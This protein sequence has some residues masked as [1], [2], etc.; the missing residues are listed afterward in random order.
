MKKT[1]GIS[2]IFILLFCGV[3]YSWAMTQE[4]RNEISQK[5]NAVS[6]SPND[7]DAHFDLA[8]TYAY[9]NKVEAGLNE[10]KKTSTLVKD[11]KAYAKELI[12]RYFDLVKKNPED[13]KL[14]FRLGFAYYF[15]DYKKYAMDELQNV[16]NVNPG[17]PWPY[18][19]MAIIAAEDNKWN[20]GILYMKKA[21]AIDSNV[22][23]FHLGLGQGYYKTG[24]SVKGFFE[25]AEA[26]RLRAIG[27]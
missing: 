22:A 24:N 11:Q 26:L 20:D 15:G 9:T 27:Y 5:E 2:I 1:A 4:Y 6:R 14:R 23:A 13:W 7:P 18:G 3:A 10:L 16:A 12:T 17:N 19:Y 8:I 21:I 25:T